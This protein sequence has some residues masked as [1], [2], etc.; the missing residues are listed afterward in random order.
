M[1]AMSEARGCA[2]AATSGC[3]PVQDGARLRRDALGQLQWRRDDGVWVGPVTPV[4]AFPIQAP[5]AE[6]ALLGPDGRELAYWADPGVL[7]PAERALLQQALGEREFLPRILRLVEVS[8]FATPS[9]WTVETDR[10]RTRF[11]LKGEEDIRRIAPGVLL[12]Q[13]AHGLH[14]LIRDPQRLDRHSRRLLDRFM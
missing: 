11:V 7:P 12:V 5:Q 10:G 9:T 14:Y 4:R 2:P 1:S 13:D 3:E 6:V 8:S